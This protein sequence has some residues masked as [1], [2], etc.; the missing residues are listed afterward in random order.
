MRSGRFESVFRFGLAAVASTGIFLASAT[1]GEATAKRAPASVYAPP[2]AAMVVDAK[3][4][5][6]LHAENPDALRHPASVTK[7][8]TLY[9]LFEQMN[10]GRMSL[11]TELKVSAFAAHQAPS[12]LALSPGDT[13]RVEDAIKALITKSANDVAVVV[14]ENIAGSEQAFA[15]LMT[16]KAR[17]LGMSKTV[18]R[19]ASGL[20]DAAQVTTARDLI[21]LGRAIQDRFP[22][23]YGYFSTRIFNF[24]GDSYSNHNKLLGRVEGVDG[25]KTGFTRMSGFNLLTSVRHEGRQLVAVVLGGR[26][27]PSRDRIMAD[28]IEA[29]LQ[30]AHAGARTAPM[31]AENAAAA[32]VPATTA[33][34]TQR[35]ARAAA[36][37]PATRQV[38]QGDTKDEAASRIP[39]AP[40]GAA[41]AESV[42]TS[43][44]SAVAGGAPM[45]W[46]KGAEPA[47]EKQRVASVEPKTTH[48]PSR[49]WFVQVGTADTQAK[50]TALASQAR[51]KSKGLLGNARTVTE[52]V[53]LKRGT[54]Y[55][56]RFTGLDEEGAEAACRTLRKAGMTCIAART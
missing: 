31:I 22:R 13:I 3:T 48:R 25:I 52:R 45:R 30:R 43:A 56:A 35:P 36:T 51:S 38:E 1:A 15:R 33:A 4:G 21:T 49:N 24:D 53:D 41:A 7:V 23:E 17:A 8:M 2:Y 44:S 14:A 11:D 55:R 27:G 5:R 37:G 26:S 12:K 10:R 40:P 29:N 18:F 34:V 42:R 16:Q 9:L 32:E 47:A 54:T 19:N 39:A 28:L 46:S 50:A 6:I 20:P